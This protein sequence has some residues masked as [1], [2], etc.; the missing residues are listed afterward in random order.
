KPITLWGEP[1]PSGPWQVAQLF[2]KMYS[3]SAFGGSAFASDVGGVV[4][5][6]AACSETAPATPTYTTPQSTT[7]G[8]PRD[9]ITLQP[10]RI[11]TAR[12]AP[13]PCRRRI[14]RFHGGTVRAPRTAGIP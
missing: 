12:A 6:C 1:F 14:S 13:V 8:R 2:L 10:E 7:G 5:S 11:R 4:G 3:P 9:S